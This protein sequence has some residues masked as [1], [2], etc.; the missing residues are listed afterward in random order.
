MD[1][2]FDPQHLPEQ[3]NLA[4]VFVDRQLP[5]FGDSPALYTDST[6]VTYRQ[7]AERAARAA[8]VFR[9][10]GLELEQRVLLMLPDIPEFAYAWFGVS[11]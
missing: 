9:G 1:A 6:T 4:D 2:R 8:S 11:K 10:L 7:L 5:S 3:L